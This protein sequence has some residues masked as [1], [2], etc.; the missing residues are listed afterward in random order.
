MT[1]LRTMWRS[2]IRVEGQQVIT[3]CPAFRRFRLIGVCPNVVFA[4]DIYYHMVFIVYCLLCVD[5]HIISMLLLSLSCMLCTVFLIKYHVFFTVFYLPYVEIVALEPRVFCKQAVVCLVIKSAY[6][7]PSTI[8]TCEIS[9]VCCCCY[10]YYWCQTNFLSDHCF[11]KYS[12]FFN[13]KS[14]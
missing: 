7:L 12:S 5:Y 14:L 2:R 8:P 9:L 11:S 3:H 4:F 6:T 10:Y 13:Y 1:R